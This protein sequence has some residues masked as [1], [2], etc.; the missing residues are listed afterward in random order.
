MSDRDELHLLAGAYALGALDDADKTRFEEFLLTSEE[1]RAEVASL[2][3]TAVIL[4]LA[5]AP[6]APPA[7]LKSRLM[8]QIAAT[9][10]LQPVCEPVL[11]APAVHAATLSAVPG[12]AP[13]PDAARAIRKAS[14]SPAEARADARWYTRPVTVLVAAAAAVAL[15]VGGNLLGLANAND[16]QQQAAS[17]AELSAASDLRRSV[18]TL[19]GGGEA[20]LIW[21]LELRRSAVVID[22][23]PALP[24]GKTYELWY[25]DGSGAKPA[26]TFDAV[27]SGNTVRVLDGS[28]SSGDTV[29]ITVEP[30]GGSDKPTTKP[31]VAI[32]SA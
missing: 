22:K 9:P 7:D 28:M 11:D 17:L 31:I 5:S 23:L 20:T 26:G 32:P 30:S 15:F 18:S 8:A 16:G 24:V 6:E 19:A 1:A 13:S 14:E 12:A 21:S 10:Q 4:G 3:D 29:G 27:P 2:S 25:I